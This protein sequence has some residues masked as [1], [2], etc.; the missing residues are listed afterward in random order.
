MGLFNFQRSKITGHLLINIMRNSKT[1]VRLNF[2]MR[3]NQ[4]IYLAPAE[5]FEPPTPRFDSG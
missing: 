2:K 5:G 1:P 4:L 3:S